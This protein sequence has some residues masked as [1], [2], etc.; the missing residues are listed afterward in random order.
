MTTI[1][2]GINMRENKKI[3]FKKEILC[4][5]GNASRDKFMMR[6]REVLK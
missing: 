5:Q 4:F 2:S 1:S 3:I 6:E